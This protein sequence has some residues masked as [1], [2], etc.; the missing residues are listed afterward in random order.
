[1]TSRRLA[2]LAVLAAALLALVAPPVAV[3]DDDSISKDFK[4][5]GKKGKAGYRER[6]E[7]W[8]AKTLPNKDL[9]WLA[10]MWDEA[11]EDDKAIPVY[12]KYLAATDLPEKNS[13]ERALDIL[14]EIHV[15][16]RDWKKVIE[17]CERF[18]KEFPASTILSK[19]WNEQG[20]AHR[21]LGELDKALPALT[22][23]ADL[24][25]NAGAI[26]LADHLLAEGKRDE[27][28]AVIEKYVAAVQQ[29]GKEKVLNE[30]KWMLDVIG[31]PAPSLEKAVSVGKTEAPKTLVGKPTLMVYWQMSHPSGE[32]SLQQAARIEQAFGDALQVIAVSTYDHY[33]PDTKKVEADMEPAKEEGYWRTFISQSRA[34]S[35]A[36]VVPDELKKELR[37]ENPN[38][39]ILVDAEGKFRYMRITTEV[40]PYGWLAVEEAVKR[41]LG[42]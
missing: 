14:V 4:E 38:Q 25:L 32:V 3:A 17:L 40:S 13:R 19:S 23:A 28:K 21:L 10:K 12:E 34:P 24:G 31:K 41:L 22:Q 16:K 36:I 5:A 30:V 2:V 15:K 35:M 1:M 18:R 26:D 9:Y 7:F 8:A 33:N 39:K 11:G 37:L 6:A 29:P 42:K 27:A 20:R